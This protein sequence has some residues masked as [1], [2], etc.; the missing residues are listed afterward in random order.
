VNLSVPCWQAWRQQDAVAGEQIKEE[1]V[2]GPCCFK[3]TKVDDACSCSVNSASVRR[4]T[5]GK[6]ASIVPPTGPVV[7]MASGHTGRS[8]T[9]S[10]HAQP[11]AVYRVSHMSYFQGAAGA[12][13]ELGASTTA[14]PLHC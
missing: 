4:I 11:F 9:C 12:M 2:G 8:I 3:H 5:I 1:H 14:V 10:F 6:H 7:P 13:A